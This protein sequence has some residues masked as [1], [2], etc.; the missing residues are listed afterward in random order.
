MNIKCHIYQ[1]KN[2]LIYLSCGDGRVCSALTL[3]QIADLGLDLYSLDNFSL[4]D[5]RAAY[6]ASQ[7]PQ[8]A[9]E[10][11]LHLTNTWNRRSARCWKQGSF[12]LSRF[13]G[14]LDW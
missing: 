13:P 11:N 10:G 8:E 3:Q 5:F 2:G 6:P 1:A 7:S 14:A 9:L 12:S 4:K